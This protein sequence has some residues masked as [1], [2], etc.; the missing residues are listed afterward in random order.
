LWENEDLRLIAVTYMDNV[1]LSGFQL[2]IDA[3]KKAFKEYVVIT[4]LSVIWK[5]LWVYYKFGTDEIS[6]YLT[7][8]I[9][10]LFKALSTTTR[11]E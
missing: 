6:P 1:I 11:K 2:T 7:Y 10:I 8:N 5:H 3:I 9:L 4:D